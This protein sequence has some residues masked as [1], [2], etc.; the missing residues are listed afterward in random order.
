MLFR[1]KLIHHIKG[2]IPKILFAAVLLG[3]SPQYLQAQEDF[4]QVKNHF[5]TIDYATSFSKAHTLLHAPTDHIL[6]DS[7]HA[8]SIIVT[9]L[10]NCSFKF[11]VENGQNI[12]GF[13]WLFGEGSPPAFS[14]PVFHTY[15]VAGVYH[16]KLYISNGCSVDTLSTTVSC[17]DSGTYISPK[18][19]LPLSLSIYP[20]PATN[21]L[22]LL[23]VAAAAGQTDLNIIDVT[24]SIVRKHKIKLDSGNNNIRLD[25]SSL[26]PGM[27][28]LKMTN[29]KGNLMEK[30]VKR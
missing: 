18:P 5:Q 4:Q 2:I 17:I 28:F 1:N 9:A 10:G 6:C 12:T 19:K 22:T 13:E 21:Q 23:C 8:D 27:Y 3:V 15:A 16:V 20:N 30:F 29:S 24:G 25:I 7:V 26:A 11:E 14:T